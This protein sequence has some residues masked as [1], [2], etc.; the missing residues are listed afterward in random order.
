MARDSSGAGFA[1]EL[2]TNL[3]ISRACSS[4]DRASA[5]GAEGRRFE[6]CRARHFNPL[7]QRQRQSARAS[8][9]VRQRPALTD[10]DLSALIARA[11]AGDADARDQAVE[12]AGE[13]GDD[14]TLA[15]LAA[16]G[17][18]D[19]VDQLV[20]LA[21]E[22]G[23][24][25]ALLSLARQGQADAAGVLIELASEHGDVETLRLLAELGYADARDVL[26]EM[27]SE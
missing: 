4:V 11:E 22:R 18:R 25:A 7:G 15:R 26:E 8:T 23:D 6:S 24:K 16:S 20:Q 3:S 1:L 5:S 10:D 21:A 19:A 12:L 27:A 13:Q 2:S 17:S 9:P 14:A